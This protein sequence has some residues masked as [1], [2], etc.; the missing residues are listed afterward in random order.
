MAEQPPADNHLPEA[1]EDEVLRILDG[2]EHAR[3]AALQQVLL[4]HPLHAR[5]IRAWLHGAGVPLPGEAP[6]PA[7]TG[8]P[9]TLPMR[10]GPYLLQTLLGRGGFGTVYRAE[11]QEPIRRPVAVK[12]LNPG[13]D[14]R[15]VLARFAAEREALNRMDHP[16]IARLL[17]AGSTPQGRPY[18]VMELVE[19]PTLANLCRTGNLPLR[20]R[21]E[22]FLKVLDAMQ[23]AHQKAVLHRDLSS[24][25]VLVADPRG[26]AQPKIIDFGIAKSLS[27]PLL[28]GGAMTFQGTLMGTPEF[29]SPEQASGRT[30]DVDTRADVYALGVQL[31]ELLTDVLPI[32]GVLLRAQGLAGLSDVIARHQPL[33]PSQAAP[34]ERTAALQGDLDAITMKALAKARDERYATVAEFAADLRAHLADE[35]VLVVAPTTWYRLRKFVRRHRAQSAAVA[36]VGCGML[37]ALGVL[38]WALRIANRSLALAESQTAEIQA[39]ADAGFRLLAN[40]ERLR[41]AIAAEAE[42]PPPWPEHRAAFADWLRTHG[43][44]IATEREKLRA[45]LAELTGRH[46][47]SRADDPADPV[48]RYLIAALQR[49]AAE[50]DAFAGPGGELQRVQAKEAFLVGVVEPAL[51]DDAALW[52]TTIAAIKHGPA[53]QS[54]RDYRGAEIP[55]LPGLTPLG[56]HPG[57]GLFEFLDLRTHRRG[58][59]KPAHGGAS[60]ALPFS[61]DT[62]IVFV[63]V[64]V[65]MFRMGAFRGE[66]GLPQNDPAAQDDELHGQLINLDEFLIARTELTNGQWARLRGAADGG[67]DP[68]LPVTGIDWHE[69]RA[70]LRQYDLDLPTEA[71]WEHACRAGSTTPWSCAEERLGEHAWFGPQPQRVALLQPNGFGLFDV[72]GNVAEWCRDGKLPYRDS[73]PAPGTGLRGDADVRAP[74]A[75]RGGACY[76]GP[77]SARSAARAGRPPFQRDSGTGLRPIRYLRKR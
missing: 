39:R 34:K 60:A 59:A 22:L 6:G 11:Q 65:G 42:L 53:Q 64:P 63:L 74:R 54:G 29:M 68:L 3:G 62:G 58:A 23:H 19:G 77:L 56:R 69:A 72:H 7:A 26:R 16:G 36:I 28:R 24:N 35:P 30:A 25:N 45:K 1:I 10:L 21:L 50:I 48:D 9:E 70:A 43:E 75:V 61:A 18:F 51:R 47:Q 73:A 13:M 8:G 2:D 5:T 20:A 38:L 44:P 12:V 57:T 52:Q 37:V 17:D 76:Q 31:Y 32:P 66:P 71:Q 15:E 40:E 33:R 27:D 55:R 4:A 14:S 41:A 49:L 46:A 67:E